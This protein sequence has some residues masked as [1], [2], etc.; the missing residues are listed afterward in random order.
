M[1]EGSPDERALIR[2]AIQS[3]G[4][5]RLDD[6]QQII[7]STGALQYTERCAHEAADIAIASIDVIPDSEFKQALVAIAEFAV[8]RRT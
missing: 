1:R 4:L 7:R 6:V 3:G 5:K 8:D 2:E